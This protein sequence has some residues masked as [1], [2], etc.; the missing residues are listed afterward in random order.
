VGVLER[1]MPR[2]GFQKEFVDLLMACIS[3][4][5]Y[6]V[7]Y[8]DQ[9]TDGFTPSRALRQGDP[10]SPYLFLICAEGLSTLCLIERRFLA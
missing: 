4:V 8:N 9:E 7:W 3:S 10:L 2:L 1:M 6:K 5:K